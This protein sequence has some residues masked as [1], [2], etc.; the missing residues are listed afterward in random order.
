[1]PHKDPEA[2][3][4]YLK[5]YAARN[6]AYGRVKAWRKANPEKRAAQLQRYAELHPNEL[7]AKY[8]RYKEKNQEK[9]LEMDRVV[10]AKYRASHPERVSAS[11]KKYAQENKDAINAAV[12]KRKAAKLQRTPSWLTEDDLW[13]IEQAYELAVIR[14]E[15][16]GFAWHVDHVY[17][18]QGKLVSGLHTPCNLQVIPW[19]ENLRKGNRLEVRHG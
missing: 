5:A 7:A 14:T 16:F 9:I 2:R 19:Q 17:P 6:P 13:M 4:A 3:K 11:K 1:M 15:V 18:L 10:S 8:Q 12:A